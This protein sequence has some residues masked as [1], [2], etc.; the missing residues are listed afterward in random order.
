MHALRTGAVEAVS[1]AVYE[2]VVFHLLDTGLEADQVQFAAI[3]E[4]VA[5]VD[6]CLKAGDSAAAMAHFVDYWNGLGTW[7]AMQ[8]EVRDELARR[9]AKV[10]Q[11][12]TAIFGE[13]S[14]VEDF[15]G[16]RLPTLMMTGAATPAPT[17]RLVQVL[18]ACLPNVRQAVIAH[19][20]HMGP[21]THRDSVNATIL[22]FLESTDGKQ[23]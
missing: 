9:A 17:A 1:F 13:P 5:A 8:A 7:A 16:L 3:K 22:E 15:A 12:F 20:G 11:D 14:R 23:K 6:A 10:A 21:V 2:P 19:A 18:S 4:V